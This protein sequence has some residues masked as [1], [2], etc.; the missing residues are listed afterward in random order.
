MIVDGRVDA[1]E[2][3]LAHRDATGDDDVGVMKQSSLDH[4]VMADVVAAPQRHVVADA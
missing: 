3:A 4:R 1:D 2:A